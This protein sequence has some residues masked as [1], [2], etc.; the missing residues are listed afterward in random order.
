MS[1]CDCP[2]RSYGWSDRTRLLQ[3]RCRTATAWHDSHSDLG[4]LSDPKRALMA[5]LAHP[6]LSPMSSNLVVPDQPGTHA[7]T[8]LAVGYLRRSTDRQ[9]QSLGDQQCAIEAYADENSL[10]L[11]KSYVD[12]AISGTS[13]VHR[14][15]FQQMLADA[16]EPTRPFQHVVVYDVKRFGRL[17][18]DEAG[19]YRH[20]LRMHGVEV[21]YVS[22]NFNGDATDDLLRPVKQWQA[23]QES[24]DLSKVTIR[25]LLSRVEGGWWMGGTPP[26]GYDLRYEDEQKA[27]LFVLRFMPDGTKQLLD[28]AG[29]MVR[30]FAR[31]ERATVSKRDRARLLPSEPC[32]VATVE[33][34]FEMAANEERGY[35]AIAG[36]LNDAGLPTPRGPAWSKRY[37]GRW[38]SSTIR[39]ILLNPTY[40][41]DMVWNRRTDARFHK[42]SKGRAA[43]RAEAFGARLVPNPQEDWIIVPD[44]HPAL[45]SRRIFDRARQVR[46]ARPGSKGQRGTN[47]RRIGGWRGQRARYLLTGLA[48]CA[49]CGGRYE[50]CVRR[51][52][53]PRKDGSLV[54]T[55]YYGCGSYIRSGRSA[56]EFGPVAQQAFERAV[57]AGVLE[58]YSKQ[59]GGKHGRQRLQAAIRAGVGEDSG[60]I[61]EAKQRVLAELAEIETTIVQLLDNITPTNRD[62]VDRRLKQLAARQD[63]LATRDRE[64]A[65]MLLGRV[66]E[67]ELYAAVRSFVGTLEGTLTDGT[68]DQRIRAIRRCI[69][70]ITVNQKGEPVT[71]QLYEV[72]SPEITLSCSV[73]VEIV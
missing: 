73:D 40:T 15:A 11:T 12:D 46:E 68:P 58:F 59:Y 53:K 20:V 70:K 41:G 25:G 37:S 9:D 30:T 13:T 57:V 67:S 49:R 54:K 5:L 44:S 1:L 33:R 4:L 17:D 26:H 18:N 62:F 2:S 34:I 51:K 61:E 27:F 38:V 56:C 60:Q 52:G 6:E 42:I 47:P 66:Q 3:N 65:A 55:H 10:R 21:H 48:S 69:E 71:V 45:V 32:R 19:Y 31:R 23:R 63:E 29:A 50:G 16:Q 36:A 22:E 24:K 28:E 35:A 7:I 72:P 8:S 14:K 64:L 39:E 43:E